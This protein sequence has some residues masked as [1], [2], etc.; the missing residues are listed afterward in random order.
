M[1]VTTIELTPEQRREFLRTLRAEY[2]E[3]CAVCSVLHE[4]GLR[5]DFDVLE[6][7]SVE[8]AVVCGS[9]KEGYDGMVHGGIVSSLLDGAMTNCL[10]SHGKVGVTGELTVRILSA[11]ASGTT[12]QVRAWLESHYGPLYILKAE[13]RQNDQLVARSRGKFMDISYLKR[14]K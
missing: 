10:F 3:N 7:G 8:A 11:V 1:P 6:D 9:E 13:L 14:Q 5:A 12:M 2:H 4:D